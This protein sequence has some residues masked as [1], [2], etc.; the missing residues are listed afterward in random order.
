MQYAKFC[1]ARRGAGVRRRLFP[2]RVRSSGGARQGRLGVPDG[3]GNRDQILKRSGCPPRLRAV[4][5]ART[6]APAGGRGETGKRNGLKSIP[7]L[8][9]VKYELP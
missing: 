5:L 2:G 4:C 1:P 6:V 3:L 9:Y 7:V 8:K